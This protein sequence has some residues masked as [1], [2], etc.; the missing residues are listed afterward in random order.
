VAHGNLNKGRGSK[1]Y[2]PDDFS[3]EQG[4]PGIERN[5]KELELVMR[6]VYEQG[7]V[8]RRMNFEEIFHPSTL[9]LSEGAG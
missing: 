7:L 1:Y 6:Y 4:P 3:L 9:E 2:F 5:R 8:K